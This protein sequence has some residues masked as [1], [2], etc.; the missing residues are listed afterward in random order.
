MVAMSLFIEVPIWPTG[1]AHYDGAILEVTT[2]EG[3][4]VA[5][6]DIASVE[7]KPARRGRLTLEIRYRC[8]L[9]TVTRGYWVEESSE[10]ALERLV[11]AAGNAAAL[12]ASA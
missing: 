1:M 3:L 4:R 12:S 9:D 10:F 6:C 5:P 7:I 11:Q 8:G 2:G